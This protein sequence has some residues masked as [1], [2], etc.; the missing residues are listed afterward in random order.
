MWVMQTTSLSELDLCRPIGANPSYKINKN[1]E[2]MLI[3][4]PYKQGFFV[5]VR[6]GTAYRHLFSPSKEKQL[7]AM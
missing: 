3:M 2:F 5:T 4:L 7:F 6:V 1:L